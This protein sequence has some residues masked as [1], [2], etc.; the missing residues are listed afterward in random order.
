M[1][2]TIPLKRMSKADKLRV[3]EA[4]WADLAADEQGFESPSWHATALKETEEL[5]KTG[6]AKFLDW[7]EA[8]KVIRRKVS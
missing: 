6:R 5:V 3:M 1:P 4:I 8:K 7:E 2:I